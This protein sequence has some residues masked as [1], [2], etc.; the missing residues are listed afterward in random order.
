MSP[1]AAIVAGEPP[2]SVTE[3]EEDDDAGPDATRSAIAATTAII[4]RNL[5]RDTFIRTPPSLRHPPGRRLALWVTP[6]AEP[7]RRKSTVG[8]PAD[9]TPRRLES[10]VRLREEPS[11]ADDGPGVPPSE[12]GW[13]TRLSPRRDARRSTAMRR[14]PNLAA[15]L[16]SATVLLALLGLAACSGSDGTPGG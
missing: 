7:A 10:A 14:A 16:R 6:G 13:T 8:A 12:V 15:P 5:G 4:T 11:P 9:A 2:S 3:P 1:T